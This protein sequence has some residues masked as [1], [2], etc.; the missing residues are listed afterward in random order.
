MGRYQVFQDNSYVLDHH[1]Y[2]MDNN[3]KVAVLQVPRKM[4]RLWR[5]KWGKEGELIRLV[6][7]HHKCRAYVCVTETYDTIGGEKD[8]KSFSILEHGEK[9][10]YVVLMT[11]YVIIIMSL[12]MCKN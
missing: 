4:W 2:S 10:E 5:C 9:S 12:R 6:E 8:S 1:D 3:V 11:I 7:A